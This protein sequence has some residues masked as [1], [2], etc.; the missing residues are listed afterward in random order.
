MI[1][2]FVISPFFHLHTNGS[3]NLTFKFLLNL[4]EK[5]TSDGRKSKILL[6]LLCSNT[7]KLKL[8]KDSQLTSSSQS[9]EKNQNESSHYFPTAAKFSLW[10]ALTQI[11]VPFC[12]AEA[13]PPSTLTREW[14]SQKL[15]VAPS[16]CISS[17]NVSTMEEN[18][19][20]WSQGHNKGRIPAASALI[21]SGILLLFVVFVVLLIWRRHAQRNPNIWGG[22]AKNSS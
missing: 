22:L 17:T 11:K 2:L 14:V 5:K 3:I 15:H 21:P 10:F 19:T 18:L 7:L 8:R 6:F 20:D 12:A 13:A 9:K 16:Y 4:Q 1:L